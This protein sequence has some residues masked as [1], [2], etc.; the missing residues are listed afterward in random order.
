VDQ[1]LI[2]LA[3]NMTMEHK[4]I[5]VMVS[6]DGLHH[7]IKRV[8]QTHDALLLKLLRSISD[9]APFKVLFLRYLH[10]LVGVA[11]KAKNQDFLLEAVGTLANLNLPEA[12]FSEVVVQ[13]NLVDFLMKHMVTYTH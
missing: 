12:K 10:E 8:H 7:M 6:S 2:A 13:H 1:E 4:N 5:E 3:C 11:T 9:A